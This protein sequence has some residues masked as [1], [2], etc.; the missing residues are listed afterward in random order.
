MTFGIPVQ[1]LP[2]DVEGNVRLDNH[3]L[4]LEQRRNLEKIRPQDHQAE[5]HCT[6]P[7][8]YDVLFGRDK[9]SRFHAG[10]TR[11]YHL[12]DSRQEKYDAAT[13]KDERSLLAADILLIIKES[14]G[15]FL[16]LDKTSWVVVDDETARDKV[17][18]TFRTRRRSRRQASQPPKINRDAM[19]GSVLSHEPA[20]RFKRQ[21]L[22]FE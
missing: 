12:I 16:K 13:S 5:I 22:W 14:G 3:K 17:T 11:F 8:P 6:V 21:N 1:L 7:G 15:R 20:E 10:N 9:I 19:L 4:W 2:I 18:S